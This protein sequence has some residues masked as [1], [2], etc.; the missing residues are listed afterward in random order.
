MH[1]VIMFVGAILVFA[2]SVL[3]ILATVSGPP[4]PQDSSTTSSSSPQQNSQVIK[5]QG[6]IWM[7]NTTTTESPLVEDCNHLQRNI[8]KDGEWRTMSGHHRNLATYGTCVFAVRGFD[9]LDIFKVGN[10]DIIDQIDAAVAE[11]ALQDADGHYHVGAEGEF[12][13][14]SLLS[15]PDGVIWNIHHSDDDF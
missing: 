6:S 1:I 10:D 12:W 4:S 2:S 14:D 11:F 8:A 3:S 9:G 5:C 13:C 15:W 7:K